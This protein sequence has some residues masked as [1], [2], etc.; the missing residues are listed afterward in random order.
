MTNVEKGTRRFYT[1]SAFFAVFIAS[2]RQGIPRQGVQVDGA[3]DPLTFSRMSCGDTMTPWPLHS[4][5]NLE[6]LWKLRTQSKQETQRVVKAHIDGFYPIGVLYVTSCNQRHARGDT[7]DLFGPGWI[8]SSDFKV[9]ATGL[10]QNHAILQTSCPRAHQD[11]RLLPMASHM[12][13]CKPHEP[14]R[15]LGLSASGCRHF[16]SL[17]DLDLVLPPRH[18]LGPRLAQLPSVVVADLLA[19]LHGSL[20]F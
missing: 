7:S 9:L 5:S 14:L 18:A 17:L 11:R 3:S 13:L 4:I 10:G 1:V 19:P 20:R 12:P 15:F 8:V 16:V 2:K 6:S